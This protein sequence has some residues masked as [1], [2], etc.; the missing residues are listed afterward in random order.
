[1]KNILNWIQTHYIWSGAI[2]LVL[3]IGGYKIFQN[4]QST[5]DLFTVAKGD[6]VQ[7]VIV[8]GNTKAVK[9]V[10]LGFENNG[11]VA[12]TYVDVGTRVVVGQTLVSLDQSSLSADLLSAE[13]TLASS[14]ARLDELKK[15][16]RP[17]E[18]AIAQTGVD[19]AQTSVID[20][21]SNMS[22][23]LIDAYTRVDDAIHN[24]VDQLFSNPRTTN[25]QFN[26]TLTDSQ[27]KNDINQSRSDI[28]T[29]LNTW[30]TTAGNL[31][32][33]QP[34]L[35]Q[36]K[37]FVDKVALAVNSLSSSSNL[38]QTTVDGYKT[39]ISTART[40]ISTA[41]SNLTAAQEKL[42]SARSALALAKDT[43]SLKKNGNTPEVIKAQEAVV[44]Q[45]QAKVQSVQSQLS[46]MSLRSP[47]NGIV[48]KQDA[49]EGEIVTPGKTVI[50]VISDS[51]LEIES[52]VSEI[53][54]GKVSIGNPVDITLDA[55]PGETFTG[56]VTYIDPGE[57]IVGGVVNYKVTIVFSQKYPQMKSG[58][59][60]NLDIKTATKTDV[61]RIPE[62]SL[63]R[64][65]GVLSVSKKEGEKFV[66]VPVTIGL[67]GQ[68]GFV[69]VL[70]GLN[71]G[72]VI[73]AVVPVQ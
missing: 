34:N 38:S 5:T 12:R 66:E 11:K 73:N 67:V 26:P 29:T 55:F 63:I 57:T 14:Q 35:D 28:E 43:L 24:N 9:T 71:V 52:N 61:I 44:L 20:A 65:E 37:L 23:K 42:N 68:D 40:N 3:V 16:T 54:I 31:N 62:Y 51:D 25:P 22:S 50:S 64:K 21:E 69:E 47:L 48:T 59:T 49:K 1:M 41:I 15:G 53:N 17:E 72:D 45:N 2:I 27:L 56:T 36:I 70:S 8:T 33:P 60:T 39:S 18:I 32:A 58:L 10:E 6:V 7:R 19:N 4:G 13:A 46:K 30:K